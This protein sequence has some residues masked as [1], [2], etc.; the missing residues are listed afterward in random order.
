MSLTNEQVI[1]LEC[2][3]TELQA[4]VAIPNHVVLPGD[5]LDGATLSLARTHGDPPRGTPGSTALAPG[6]QHPWRGAALRE[7]PLGSR[8]YQRSRLKTPPFRAGDESR[9][10]RKGHDSLDSC[11]VCAYRA[12]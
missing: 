6:A 3:E 12:E 10:A 11:R 9:V 8:P 2:V 1:W 7:P 4:P 5:S